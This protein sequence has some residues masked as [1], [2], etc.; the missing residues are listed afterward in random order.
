MF[1]LKGTLAKGIESLVC[2]PTYK[3]LVVTLKPENDKD[4]EPNWF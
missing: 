1:T 2:S 3:D 4:P